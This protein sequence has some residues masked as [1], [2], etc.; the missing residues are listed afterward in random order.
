VASLFS[1]VKLKDG[2]TTGDVI[3]TAAND[4]TARLTPVG[5]G[6]GR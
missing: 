4:G 2:G 5:A 3:V 6:R 1:R